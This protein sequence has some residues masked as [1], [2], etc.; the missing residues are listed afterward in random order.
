MVMNSTNNCPDKSFHIDDKFFS[1]LISKETSK[2]NN[3]SFRVYYGDV[4]GA[5]PFTWETRPGTPKHMTWTDVTLLPPLTPPPAYQNNSVGGTKKKGHVSIRSKLL[6]ALLMRIGD[7][8]GQGGGK[9][10]SHVSV[11]PSSSSSLSSLSWS[12]TSMTSANS[13]SF[14]ARRGFSSF[15][16]S[17][18]HDVL[19]KD[20]HQELTS[21]VGSSRFCFGLIRSRSKIIGHGSD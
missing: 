9:R 18:D 21:T 11:S 12:S 2:A 14:H 6:R 19:G 20:E 10:R 3:P 15:G 8:G 7:A 5:V 17:F 13:S 4:S 1:K 16:S